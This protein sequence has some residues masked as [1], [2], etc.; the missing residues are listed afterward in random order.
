MSTFSGGLGREEEEMTAAQTPLID[1]LR[2]VQHDARLTYEHN[3]T[4]HQMIPVGRLCAQAANE[5]VALRAAMDEL[6]AL[7]NLKERYT[8]A[9]F[10]AVTKGDRD[11]ALALK[12]EYENEYKNR[13]PLAWAEARRLRGKT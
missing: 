5:I 3:P 4:H 1:L 13:Q 2:S 8:E 12:A 11:V 6:I 10:V 9:N 7:K